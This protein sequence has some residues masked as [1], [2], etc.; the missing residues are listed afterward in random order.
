MKCAY[1]DVTLLVH[2]YLRPRMLD[3]LIVRV[4]SLIGRYNYTDDQVTLYRG[5]ATQHRDL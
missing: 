5:S 2:V 4:V 3:L 1:H